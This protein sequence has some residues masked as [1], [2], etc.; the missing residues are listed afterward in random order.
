M[1]P[2][3][4]RIERG[5]IDPTF[6]VTHKMALDEAPEGYKMFRDK[7]DDCTKVVLKPDMEKS[8]K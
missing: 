8:N 3:L 2:L 6:V 1:R 7:Q 4:E 5:D